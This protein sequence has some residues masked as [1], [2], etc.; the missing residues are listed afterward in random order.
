MVAQGDA[1]YGAFIMN[2][3]PGIKHGAS[4]LTA[5]EIL[6]H[7]RFAD[8]RRAHIDRVV[9]LFA[10]DRFVT[11]L[12]RDAATISLRGFVVAFDFVHDETDR[13]TWATPAQLRKHLVERGL[14]SPR[15][16]DDLLARFRHEKL[17]VP[18]AP[19]SDRRVRILKPAAQLIA[20]DRDHLAAYQHFL[21]HLYP[22]RG[23]E[24]TID[25]DPRVQIEIRKSAF[26][27]TPQAMAFMRHQPFM[28][29]LARDAG[30]LLFLLVA[31]F[32]LAGGGE[33]ISFTA[34]ADKLG[35]SRTHI[36]NVFVEAENA[37]YV[38][39]GDPGR[40]VVILPVLWDAYDRFLADVQ[41]A[42]DAIAQ[43][44]FANL[45]SGSAKTPLGAFQSESS[46]AERT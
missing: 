23:Y 21:L 40:P 19:A 30:Y 35:V 6:S 9:A 28:M 32:Q 11:R 3:D 24:W 46:Q 36:R 42:Q 31:Q 7:P 44:A 25:Q 17:V 18:V 41:A 15:R 37:G 39:L 5:E 20:H 33:D 13:S 34:M 27:A 2:A 14:A 4:S 16:I 10:G 8:A 26:R 22:G 38:Q 12:M 43:V 45:A 29:F 1:G